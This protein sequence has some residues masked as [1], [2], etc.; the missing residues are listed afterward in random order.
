MIQILEN[1]WKQEMEKISP[2][3]RKRGKIK[4]PQHD[5]E[6]LE[7]SRVHLKEFANCGEFYIYSYHLSCFQLLDEDQVC[8]SL[9][10]LTFLV[11]NFSK[12]YH[13]TMKNPFSYPAVKQY[14]EIPMLFKGPI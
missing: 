13:T 6:S 14:A 8:F 1:E 2:T 3:F 4:S 11:F 9:I 12:F 7:E 5:L 10:C